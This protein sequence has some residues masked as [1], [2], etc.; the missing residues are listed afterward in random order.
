MKQITCYFAIKVVFFL[1]RFTSLLQGFM[2]YWA[3]FVFPISPI[4]TQHFLFLHPL[5][6]P[7]L[8][9]SFSFSFILHGNAEYG[10]RWSWVSV[11]GTWEW[12]WVHCH[13]NR[14][15]SVT[16]SSQRRAP[17]SRFRFSGFDANLGNLFDQWRREEAAADDIKPGVGPAIAVEEEEAF[18]RSD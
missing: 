11:W 2:P 17:K 8:S 7:S 10:G 4:N 15:A 5:C 3:P 1:V 6:S 18:G 12:S 16:L 13:W 9:L 14:R